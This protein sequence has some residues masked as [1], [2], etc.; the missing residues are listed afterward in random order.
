MKTNPDENLIQA[1]DEPVELDFVTL[2]EIKTLPELAGAYYVKGENQENWDFRFR[3]FRERRQDGSRALHPQITASNGVDRIGLAL[4]KSHG[5]YI[6]M[7]NGN[8]PF[9][10]RVLRYLNKGALSISE[11]VQIAIGGDPDTEQKQ[12]A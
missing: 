8:M 2:D 12:C 10:Q 9:N 6:Q 1:E 4:S 11:E 7:H 5:W 3:V